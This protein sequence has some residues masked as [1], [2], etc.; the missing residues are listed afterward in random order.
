MEKNYFLKKQAK[1]YYKKYKVSDILEV[2]KEETGY[3]VQKYE[4]SINEKESDILDFI[5]FHGEKK[6]CELDFEMELMESFERENNEFILKLN[7]KNEIEEVLNKKAMISNIDDKLFQYMEKNIERSGKIIDTVNLYKKQFENEGELELFMNTEGMTSYL[8][9]D[10]FDREYFETKETKIIKHIG[11]IVPRIAIPVEFKFK[12]KKMTE[13][14]LTLYFT[15]DYSGMASQANIVLAYKKYLG[16]PEHEKFEFS[17][18]IK[19][20][21]TI[22]IKEN[23][24]KKYNILRKLILSGNKYNRQITIEGIQE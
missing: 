6:V 2:E 3:L 10:I 19:G 5:L 20:Q 15:S 24:L 16:L 21:Y 8:F 12:I 13:D 4:V 11:N 1:R 17:L 14:E 9:I 7:E 18:D 23:K 22:N